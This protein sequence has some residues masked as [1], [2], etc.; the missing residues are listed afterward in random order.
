MQGGKESEG[1]KICEPC[2][3]LT[4]CE[5]AARDGGLSLGEDPGVFELELARNELK[6]LR[7]ACPPSHQPL[8]AWY[9][10]LATLRLL[11]HSSLS[12][13]TGVSP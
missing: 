9:A 11:S 4:E 5:M 2:S 13:L 6:E 1:E 3:P 12:S 10:S 7:Q 8:S